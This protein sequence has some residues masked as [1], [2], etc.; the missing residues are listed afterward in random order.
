MQNLVSNNKMEIQSVI[1]SKPYSAATLST[2]STTS[3]YRGIGHSIARL[4]ESENSDNQLATNHT[5]FYG[6]L[7]ANLLVSLYIAVCNAL[8]FLPFYLLI[9][10][11]I[12][13]SNIK[14]EDRKSTV[15]IAL[16]ATNEIHKQPSTPHTPHTP[17]N[18]HGNGDLSSNKSYTF[19]EGQSNDIGPN[20]G[21]FM[22]APTPAQLGRAPL[23]RRQSMGT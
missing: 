2:I 4:A 8:I 13:V 5:Q 15:N 17:Q 9:F 6:N 3:S 18:N 10:L 16:P 23:Q 21:P 7:S 19:D 11:S 20:K 14:T 1:V 22:L 12:T